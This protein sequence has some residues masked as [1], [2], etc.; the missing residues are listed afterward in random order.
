MCKNKMCYMLQL[1]SVVNN[2]DLKLLYTC[3]SELL[4]NWRRK[5]KTIEVDLILLLK[6]VSNLA[7]K[8]TNTVLD[9]MVIRW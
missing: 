1:S 4:V 3:H 2:E 6:N 7:T 9:A 5:S 8:S